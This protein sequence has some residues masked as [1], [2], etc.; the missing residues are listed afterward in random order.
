MSSTDR[1]DRTDRGF[2]LIEL[3]VSVAIM[4]LLALLSWQM[5]TTLIHAR[6]QTQARLRKL[7]DLQRCLQIL[8]ADVLQV[9]KRPI[10]DEFGGPMPAWMGEVDS[11]GRADIEF[12]RGGWLN[13]MGEVRSELVRV[14]Y[15]VTSG[16]LHRLSWTQLDRAPGAKPDDIV[17][18]KGVS[19]WQ[20][21][22]LDSA[23]Q[24]QQIWPEPVDAQK[25]VAQQPLPIALEVQF[26]SVDFGHL[27]CLYVVPPGVDS[28]P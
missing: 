17:V 10:T 21:R 22:Y 28:G 14:H 18:L 24:W 1:T 12:T 25:D 20:L 16:D 2:T 5:L 9:V 19:H 13:P 4:A 7:D 27:R 11:E 3:M 8:D 6:D 15:Q 23:G 26:D